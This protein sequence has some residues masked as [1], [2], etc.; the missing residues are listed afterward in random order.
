MSSL[1]MESWRLSRERQWAGMNA[2]D[3]DMRHGGID[4]LVDSYEIRRSINKLSKNTDPNTNPAKE[5]KI[6]QAIAPVNSQPQTTGY[7]PINNEYKKQS[8]K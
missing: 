5:E 6:S 3:A 4:M 2:S 7:N 8:E 1:S